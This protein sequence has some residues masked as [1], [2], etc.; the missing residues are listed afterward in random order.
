VH[1][2]PT[3]RPPRARTLAAALLLSLGCGEQGVITAPTQPIA[4]P[5]AE[6]SPALAFPDS[7]VAG[8]GVPPYADTA[9]RLLP[10]DTLVRAEVSVS[11]PHVRGETAVPAL[12]GVRVLSRDTNPG[13]LNA[14][15]LALADCPIVLRLHRT[16][17]RTDAPAWR[18]DAAQGAL[19][20]PP[21]G[22]HFAGETVVS[23]PLAAVLGDSLPVGRYHFAVALRL[24]DGRT[25]DFVA[26]GAHLD[27]APP[28]PSRDLRALR[29]GARVD[30]VGAGPRMLRT[31]ALLVNG[32]TQPV[33]FEHGAC[34]LQLR[35]S[36]A[37]GG[38]LPVPRWHSANRPL[39]CIAILLGRVLQ[40]G[41]SAV[42]TLEVPLRAVLGDSMPPGR[43]RAVAELELLNDDLSADRWD[44]RYALDAGE[45]E[46]PGDRDP[47]PVSRTVGGVTYTAATRLVRGSGGADTV[48]TL[49][50]ATNAGAERAI[51][52]VVRGCPVRMFAYRSAE[53]RDAL[54]EP[55]AMSLQGCFYTPTPF[56]LEP[57]ASW[58]FQHDVPVAELV[59]QGGGG[60]YWFAAAL[61]G[62]PAGLVAAGELDL[63]G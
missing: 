11:P 31:T 25:L 21:V 54:G 52:Q 39:A 48:R 29:M 22:G 24:A 38:L 45:I 53:L 49:V 16:A 33:Q 8:M 42:Y 3:P 27:P 55:A 34:L 37:D 56:A 44:T 17:A 63:G 41:D 6:P 7:I 2:I 46:L 15:P 12:L 13:M 28:T 51:A 60:R 59:R 10:P 5:P 18:S 58:V 14:R 20:C 57:G 30:L 61:E 47:L 43:Y 23:F 35:L 19:A 26:G 50:R 36:R 62:A 32:G 9:S 1:R 4:P 40:P